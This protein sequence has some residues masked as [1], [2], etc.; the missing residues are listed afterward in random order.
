MLAQGDLA[1]KIVDDLIARSKPFG[2]AITLENGIGRV[3]LTDA[4]RE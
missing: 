3:A 2:T 4:P 1:K